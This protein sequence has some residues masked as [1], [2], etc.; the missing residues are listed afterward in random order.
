MFCHKCGFKLVSGSI[1]CSR[2]GTRVPPE[3]LEEM[4][5]EAGVSEPEQIIKPEIKA[6]PESKTEPATVVVSE[7]ELKPEVKVEPE[8]K[9]EPK[10]EPEPEITTR[11]KPEPES[12]PEQNPASEAKPEIKLEPAPESKPEPPAVRVYI[13][14]TVTEQQIKAEDTVV[15]RHEC[16][17][18]PMQLT[19]HG[20]MRDGMKLRL[21]NAKTK[22]TLSGAKQIAII[23]FHVVP[24]GTR[25]MKDSPKPSEA[26]TAA[27]QT[28]VYR[29]LPKTPARKTVSFA[30]VS[31][32]IAFQLCAE[33]ELKTGFQF[34]GADDEGSVDIEPSAMTLYKKSKGVALAFGA[35][36]SA[37][38]GKGKLVATIRPADIASFEKNT[39]GGKFRDYRIHLKDGRLLKISF[40]TLQLNSVL[41]ATDQFLSQI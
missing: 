22:R 29:E 17:E 18:E 8:L 41:S 2:C 32:Q 9:T 26:Q 11:L 30:P 27:R 35:I 20:D 36:G 10:A 25:I 3:I 23:V 24:Y 19:L 16:L 4:E 34:G 5:R 38:E 28:P 21:T 39:N 12:K 7:P 33:S 13:P 37:I 15:V 1:F 31:S 6:E 14:L 40:A